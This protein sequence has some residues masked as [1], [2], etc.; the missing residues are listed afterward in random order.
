LEDAVS[1]LRNGDLKSKIVAV[2]TI[3]IL[4]MLLGVICAPRPHF[5]SQVNAIVKPSL[6]SSARWEFNAIISEIKLSVLGKPGDEINTSAVTRYFDITKQLQGLEA[7][8]N[9]PTSTDP[10]VT[11]TI[12]H[13][14]AEQAAL[15]TATE[16]TI[17][18]QIRATLTKDGIF[19]PFFLKF[20]FPPIDFKLNRPPNMLIIS[21]RDRIVEIKSIML[22]PDLSTVEME[23]LEAKVDNLNVSA[24]VVP[25]GGLGTTFPTFVNNGTDLRD[26]LVAAVHEYLHQYLAFKPLGFRYV[27]DLLGISR[28]YDMVT[29]NETVANMVS[30][31]IGDQIYEEYYLQYLPA[32][33]P[34]SITTPAFDFNA[35]MRDIRKTVDAYLANG[36]AQQAE[37][38]MEEQRQFLATKGY[39]IRKLNQAYFAFYGT[40]ADSPTSVS[41]IGTKVAEIRDQSHSLKDFLSKVSRITSVQDLD[42]LLQ[43]GKAS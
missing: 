30:K 38:Y 23:S 42:Q 24:L 40:Y 28:N 11:E 26:A 33:L 32:T 20:G 19:N 31:E 14:K 16:K 10:S 27:I 22:R 29:I 15:E 34:Q 7:S 43:S 25:L 13:L 21:P 39:Y 12:A 4:I 37:R 18:Q 2:I 5:N 8:Q 35:A 3:L 6:F 1:L 36:Q 9:S 41:P 17:E